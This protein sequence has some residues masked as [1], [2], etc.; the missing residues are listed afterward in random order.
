VLTSIAQREDAER[1]AAH[2][3]TY[4]PAALPADTAPPPTSPGR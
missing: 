4:V 1:L 2:R 3:A